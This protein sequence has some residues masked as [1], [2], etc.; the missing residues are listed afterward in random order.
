MKDINGK[1]LDDNLPIEVVMRL[2]QW[3]SVNNWL[4]RLHFK[5]V[6]DVY[7]KIRAQL[8]DLEDANKDAIGITLSIAE[9]NVVSHSLSFAPYGIVCDCMINIMTQGQ[10]E[11]EDWKTAFGEVENEQ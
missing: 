10:E 9:Y 4:S 7:G 8:H 11:I 3:A 5:E 2:D 1:V 6:V